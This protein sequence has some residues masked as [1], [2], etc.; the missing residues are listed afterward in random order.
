VPD[1]CSFEKGCY[2]GQEVINRIDVMGQ[3]QKKLWG[4]ELV[5]PDTD[6]PAMG[7]DVFLGEDSVGTTTSAVA[8][9]GHRRV[10]AVLRKSVWKPGLEL[11]VGPEC[12]VAV[13]RDLPFPEE[14]AA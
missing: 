14:G 5:G 13:V 8:E 6:L 2:I 10:L 1:Y 3:V 4:L 12:R 9:P 7:S 11:R